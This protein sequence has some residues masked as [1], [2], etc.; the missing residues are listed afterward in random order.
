MPVSLFGAKITTAERR[1][2]SQA[3][4]LDRTRFL[5][6]QTKFSSIP[7]AGKYIHQSGFPSSGRPHDANQLPAVESSR[8]TLQEGFVT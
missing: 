5:G 4:K 8:Q 3:G 6:T 2:Q 1:T 7:V